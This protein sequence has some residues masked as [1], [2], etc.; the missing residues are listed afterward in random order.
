MFRLRMLR[1]MRLLRVWSGRD[2]SCVE[3]GMS[4]DLTWTGPMRA[5]NANFDRYPPDRHCAN[6]EY[7]QSVIDYL[8]KMWK[9]CEINSFLQCC[10]RRM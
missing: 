1:R 7:H 8:P 3:D 2:E 6:S 9:A 4:S 10:P 5:F